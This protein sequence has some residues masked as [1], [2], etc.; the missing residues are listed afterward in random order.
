[1]ST[2]RGF[3]AG[4]TPA[5]IGLAGITGLACTRA[6]GATRTRPD[7]YVVASDRAVEWLLTRLRDD[8]SFGPDAVDM[9]CYHKAPYILG[10]AGETVAANRSL[11][12]IKRQFL[13]PDGDF[14][15]APGQKADLVKYNEVTW[16]YSNG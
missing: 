14:M 13:Q 12:W 15:I 7:R 5:T 4:L 8:G 2:R 9:V 10:L 1:M 3:L 16:G 11:T 6:A